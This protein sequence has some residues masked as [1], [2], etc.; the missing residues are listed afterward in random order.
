VKDGVLSVVAEL[1]AFVCTVAVTATFR[2]CRDQGRQRD[3]AAR[4][5]AN[6]LSLGTSPTML[7]QI[8]LVW[9]GLHF[10]TVHQRPLQNALNF[11]QSIT[12]ES[13][14]PRSAVYTLNYLQVNT[15]FITALRSGADKKI[16]YPMHTG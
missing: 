16:N 2:L 9:F 13:Q 3:G 14:S 7:T 1:T 12:E 11:I 15:K 10:V 5:S 6:F 8:C 4:P